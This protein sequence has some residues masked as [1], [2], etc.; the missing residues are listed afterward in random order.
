MK[1]HDCYMCQSA[2]SVNQWGFCEICCEELEDLEHGANW[3]MTPAAVAGGE[4]AFGQ[5]PDNGA[6]DTEA[7]LTTVE[8]NAA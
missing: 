3:K 6:S 4:T 2:G 7:V 1:R 8:Q 5:S